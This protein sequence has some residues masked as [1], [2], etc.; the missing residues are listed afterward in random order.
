MKP[1]PPWASK[2]DE[3]ILELLDD[4]ETVLPP[5]AVEFNLDYKGIASPA[6]ST[7]KRRMRKLAEHGFLN[8]VE[9]KSGYYVISDCGRAYLSGELDADDF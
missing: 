6:Y 9:G 5:A 3:P 4:S 1:R 7:V 8:R 2:Y